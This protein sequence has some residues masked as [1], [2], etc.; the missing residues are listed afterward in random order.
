[1]NYYVDD[2]VNLNYY[3]S[4]DDYIRSN[5]STMKSGE[6]YD[7]A[8]NC[9]A[10]RHILPSYYL[11]AQVILNDDIVKPYVLFWWAKCVKTHVEEMLDKFLLNYDKETSVK[12]FIHISN[13][14]NKKIKLKVMSNGNVSEW[15]DAVNEKIRD[16]NIHIDGELIKSYSMDDFYNDLPVDYKLGIML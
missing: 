2:A 15:V 10:R 14:N 3:L 8:E 5:I 12:W 16:L 7:I 13:L 9:Y 4:D 11:L 1:M 6:A